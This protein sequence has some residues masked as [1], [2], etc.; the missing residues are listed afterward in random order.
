MY[1]CASSDALSR[2]NGSANLNKKQEPE[3]YKPDASS[4]KYEPIRNLINTK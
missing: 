2:A 3:K 4:N 1:G